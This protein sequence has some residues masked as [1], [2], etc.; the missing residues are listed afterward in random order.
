[1]S[2]GG[3]GGRASLRCSHCG[4]D[5]AGTTHTR[6]TYRVDYYALHTGDVEPV[7]VQRAD[8]PE[9]TVIVLRL[10]RPIDVYTCVDCLRHPAVRAER[11]R[12]FRPELAEGAPQT[13]AG[14]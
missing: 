8:D 11:E 12:R 9:R 2:A 14:P 13:G 3:P 4:R 6:T 7:A 10:V 1:M 5:V